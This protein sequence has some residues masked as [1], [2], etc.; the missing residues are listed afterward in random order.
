MNP[1]KTVRDERFQKIYTVKAEFG[2]NDYN[3]FFVH[4]EN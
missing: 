3:T 1:S 4:S 2:L